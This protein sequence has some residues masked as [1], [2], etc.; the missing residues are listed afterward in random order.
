MINFLLS[1][2]LF[3]ECPTYPLV[4]TANKQRVSDL[5][6]WYQSFP[7]SNG[8]SSRIIGRSI[9]LGSLA[10]QIRHF[11]RC[12]YQT[13]PFEESKGAKSARKSV[14]VLDSCGS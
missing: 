1:T 7:P 11:H 13:L 9:K 5:L 12:R 8:P 14:R 10:S 6:G 2:V 3:F 4:F